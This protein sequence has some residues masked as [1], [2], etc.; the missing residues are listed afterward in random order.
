MRFLGRLLNRTFLT[1]MKFT[2]FYRDPKANLVAWEDRFEA[3]TR[4][5]SEN[6]EKL[7][8]AD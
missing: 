3:A 2:A 5:A 7:S 6:L 1:L 4:R 8:D